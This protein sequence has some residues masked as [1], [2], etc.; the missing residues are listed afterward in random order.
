[1]TEVIQEEAGSGNGTAAIFYLDNPGPKGAGTIEVSAESPNGG[2]GAA[3]ALSNTMAGFAVTN[4]RTGNAAN[5][6]TLTTAGVNSV[7][8][9]VLDNAGNPNSSGTPTVNAAAATPL[10][11]VSTGSWGGGWGGHA[12]GYRLVASPSAVTPAFTTTTG[13]GYS[14]N[15][16]AAEFAA[17]PPQPNIW[18]QSAGGTQNWTTN[19]NWEDAV[20]PA[21]TSS[22]TMDFSTVDLAADTA[23]VLGAN[24]TARIWKFGDT[25]GAENWTVN[26]GN[27]MTLAGT[28]PTIEV[29]NNTTQLNNVVVGSAGL[30]KT[31]A[32]TLFLNGNNTY[33]GVTRISAGTLQAAT[34]A[35]GSSNSSIG[36]SSN[37]V[38]NLI[39]NGGTLRYTGA[40][41][42][43]NRLFSLQASSSIDASGTGALNFTST[44]AMGFSSS[45]ADKTLTLTGNNAGANTIA[46]II[47]DNLTTGT[48]GDQDITTGLTSLTKSGTGTWV[49]SGA[50]TYTGGTIINGGTLRLTNTAAVQTSSQVNINNGSNAGTLELATNTAFATFP[51]IGGGSGAQATI[52]SDRATAGAGLTHLLGAAYFGTNTYHFSSGPN[53]TSG[54]GG[55]SFPSVNLSGGGN[56]TTVFNPTTAN[57]T[58]VGG[59][60]I[61]SGGTTKTLNLGG[62][63]VGNSIGGTIANGI[64]TL[65]LTKSNTSTWTLSGLSAIV[66]ENYS[67]ATIIDNGT[68]RIT[69]TSPSFASSL[70]FGSAAGGTNVG[71]LDLSAASATFAGA[72]RSAHKLHQCQHHYDWQWQNASGCRCL[73]GGLQ[74]HR[75]PACHHRTGR[76]RSRH[77]FHRH[78]HHAD[79][80]QHPDRQWFDHQCRQLRSPGHERPCQLPCQS[81]NRQLPCRKPYQQRQRQRRRVHC[82][83]CRQQ[84]HPGSHSLVR[85]TRWIGKQWCNCRAIAHAWHRCHRSSMWTPSTSVASEPPMAEAMAASP[86]MVPP[87]P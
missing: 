73:H 63:S 29:K 8:I 75:P 30:T 70:T 19:T 40:A 52:V 68:L 1:M 74:S 55:I 21:P 16:A 48:V 49:L 76:Q 42:S 57:L 41:V 3:Y 20:V 9:A 27:T 13:S 64:G 34:L 10:T 17:R 67:G 37:A 18:F 53:V 24:R 87:E 50:N 25:S 26:S 66:A 58:I 80:C 59:L 4:S 60:T 39:L 69:T 28:T 84:H 2:I 35:N 81:R 5:S 79:Q 51:I 36:A 6:V 86:S 83:S 78:Q 77:P 56:G 32:G 85:F 15:L 44:G 46:A 47:G 71:N 22:T 54:T 12:S 62:T 65:S 82:H 61:P 45:T 43:T 14:I 23:L 11:P 72:F 38:G 33:T 31:G 7:V